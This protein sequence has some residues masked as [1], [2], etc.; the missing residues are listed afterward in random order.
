M[1]AVTLAFLGAMSFGTADFVGG[2]YTRRYHVLAVMGVSQTA[3]LLA[4]SLLV[5][6][7]DPSVPPGPAV[8]WGLVGGVFGVVGLGFLYEALSV[9][10]MGVVSPIAALSV[11]VPMGV[12]FVGRGDRPTAL[13]IVGVIL[14][15]VG[16]VL[17]ASTEDGPGEGRRV[18]AGVW[19]A[20]AAAVTLG[21]FLVSMANSAHAGANA[22]W[23]AL[24]VRLMSVPLIW[25]AVVVRRSSVDLRMGRRDVGLL[26][27]VGVLDNLANVLVVAA[28]TL[29]LLS[30]VSAVVALIPVATVLLARMVLHEHLH[31]WQS[32]GV[33]LAI[34]GV[35]MIAGG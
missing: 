26:A 28:T 11:L 20:I 34:A 27:G 24:L 2:L 16:A 30:L 3:G 22:A 19:L 8:V 14:A 5:L 33:V 6:A 9:G 7:T 32:V 4:T 25:L 12:G 15:L 23:P 29:G 18:A 31:R 17:A 13:Q 10:R 35:V 1:L 21:M